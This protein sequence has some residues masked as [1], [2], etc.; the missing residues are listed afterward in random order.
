MTDLLR[1]ARRRLKGLLAATLW[2]YDGAALAA[3]LARLGVQPGDTAMVHASWLPGNGFLPSA[4]GGG[5]A[6][7]V[8]ALQAAV[9]P[10]GLLVMPS[11]TYHDESSA[12]FLARGGVMDVRRSASRMGLLSEVFRRAK[13]VERS[14]SPTHPLAAWGPDAASFLAGH[15]A[16]PAPFGP[17]SPFARLVARDARILLVDAPFSTV[18]FTHFLEDRIRH[19]L[20]VPFYEAAPI[21]GTVIDGQGNRLTVPTLVITEAANQA[22]R[23]P[24]LVARLEA[25][26]AIRRARL[27]NTRLAVLDAR[28]MVA[29]AD[30]MVA[31][32]D[33]FFADGQRI[34]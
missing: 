9:G 25:A 13:G 22:R 26:G 14:L 20:A 3:A 12:A 24:R 5:P 34:T 17:D 21:A 16:T 23:E 18:T 7:F 11:F 29:A 30:R 8:A 1:R 4:K 10:A 6:G 19:S 27:G 32:G 2:A 31:E 15:Q 28:A 33:S